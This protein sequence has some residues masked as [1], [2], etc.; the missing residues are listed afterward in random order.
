MKIQGIF[1]AVLTPF[2]EDGRVDFESLDCLTEF[3]IDKRVHGLF[4]LGTTGEGMLLSVEER[5]EV[6]EHVVRTVRGRV[7]VVIHA[8]EISTARTIELARHAERIGASGI[9]VVCP[10]FFPLEEREIYAHFQ[11]VAQA[12]SEDFPIF[13]YNFPNNARNEISL[14]TILQLIENH[15]NIRALKFSSDHFSRILEIINATPKEFYM[16]LGP[17]QYYLA[18]LHMGTNG[19]VSGVANVFP[20]PYVKLFEYYMQGKIEEA[21]QE[22][23]KIN[24][25]TEAL[26]YGRSLSLFKEA[27]ALRGLKGGKVRAPLRNISKEEKEAVF[28]ILEKF[29]P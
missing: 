19:C 12:V 22:Q 21:K 1:P 8:G 10:Y 11:A 28:R 4:P 27:L 7:P 3:L 26:R 29:Q 5:Q 24:F 6:A 15:R 13:L 2:H 25:L 17:D 9:S 18:G 16:M 23:L 14:N 20:E